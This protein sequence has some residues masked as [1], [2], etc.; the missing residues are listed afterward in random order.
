M[1][2]IYRAELECDDCMR[3]RALAKVTNNQLDPFITTVEHLLDLWAILDGIDREDEA[4]FDAS[5][6]PKILVPS[7]NCEHCGTCSTCLH[8]EECDCPERCPSCGETLARCPGHT[9]LSDPAGWRRINAHD[10]GDHTLCRLEVCH[11]DG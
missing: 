10:R 7:G 5:E 6:F 2:Y 1:P 4:S 3:R 11:K 8:F 9:L